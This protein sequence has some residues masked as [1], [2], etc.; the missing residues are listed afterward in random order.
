M[1]GETQAVHLS[2]IMQKHRLYPEYELAL[3]M[4]EVKKSS[5]KKLAEGDL[6]L[7]GLDHLELVLLQ[8]GK[9]CAKV[10][11]DE[12]QNTRK[13]K[14]VNLE[15]DMLSSYNSKKYKIVKCSFG[16]LQS[17]VLEV[18]HQ[19]GIAS[20]DLH[21]VGLMTEEKVWAKGSLVN[22]DDE[23]AVQIDEVKR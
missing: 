22:V 1:K 23:I 3:P 20:L 5:L 6:L 4:I 18:G 11:L 14:I 12:T 16:I 13:I 21:K 17:R 7:L 8:E 15:K 10:M 9:V 2:E 19:I